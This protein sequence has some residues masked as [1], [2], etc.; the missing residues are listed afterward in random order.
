MSSNIRH[1]WV[2]RSRFNR[3]SFGWRSQPAI[4]RIKEAVSEIRKVA[5]RDPDLGGEGAVIF[6]EKVSGALRNV[7]SSSGAMGSAV[8]WAI[9]SLVPVVA[10]AP[11]DDA[12]R[13]KWLERLWHAVEADEMP[14]IELL[15]Q[16]WGELCV[17]AE[18]ASR[19]ADRFIGDARMNR[20]RDRT[21]TGYFNGIPACLSSLF[22]AERFSEILDLLRQSPYKTWHERMWGVKALMAMGQKADALRFAEDSRGLNAPDFLISE[23]CEEILLASGMMEEA[24]DRYS[25][26]ANQKTTY[27]ATFRAI[28][29]KYSHKEPAAILKD[30]VADSPG[31][32]GKW[33]AAAKSAGLYEEAISL[34]NRTPCDP[35]TL[36]RAA[37]DMAETRPLF[38][39]NAGI[40]ALRW[41]S[42]G[43]GYDITVYDVLTAFDYTVKAAE[44]AGCLPETIEAIREIV[45]CDKSDERVIPN[46]LEMKLREIQEDRT[47]GA[48]DDLHI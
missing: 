21:W 15:P 44:A 8:N 39:R 26:A 38:A 10:D 40:A 47:P 33:F 23:A 41:L 36:T 13:E 3:G 32:E 22:R 5:S 20:S 12:L 25:F 24:Y 35:R 42:A 28:V 1:K 29:K 48:S 34:A 14:Y 9:E 43:Y 6:L 7:D 46:I 45:S 37:R 11:A 30:L 19:W 27:L 18:R 4:T 16:Y 17:T 2:F 31:N